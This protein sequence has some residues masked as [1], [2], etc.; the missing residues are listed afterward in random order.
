MASSSFQKKKIPS[1][2]ADS[3]TAKRLP[4]C[5][6]GSLCLFGRKG[7][8]MRERER[9]RERKRERVSERGLF[10]NGFFEKGIF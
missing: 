7:E 5:I 9:E 10:Q 4:T 8:R 2:V 6:K 3:V 1:F